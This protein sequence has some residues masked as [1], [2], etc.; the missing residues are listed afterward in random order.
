M[1]LLDEVFTRRLRLVRPTA[2]DF[3]DQFRLH[4]HVRVAPTL[5]G[6]LSEEEAQTRHARNLEHWQQYGFGY[7]I[8][9]DRQDDGFLGRGGLRHVMLEGHDEVE[10]GYAFIPEVWGRGLAT[11]LARESARVAFDRL[12]LAELVCFTLPTNLP[13]RRVMHKVGF[14]YER[15]GDWAGRP[16]V[17]YRLSKSRWQSMTG[18]PP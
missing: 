4:N 16:H 10:I 9:R 6:P 2:A 1:P 13:S 15:D 18:E 3:G 11:E 17:F 5:G 8:A 7:W 14:E 12:G